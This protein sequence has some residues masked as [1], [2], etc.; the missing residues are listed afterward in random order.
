MQGTTTVIREPR[1]HTYAEPLS[2]LR[3]SWG[4]VLAGTVTLFAVSIFLWLLALAIVMLAIHPAAQS[5][6]ASVLA[7]WICG[8][9]TTLIGAFVGGRVAGSL[10]GSPRRGV[11]AMHGFLSW[12]LALV[13]ASAAQAIVLGGIVRT[14]GNAAAAS[15]AVAASRET[16]E[17]R[18]QAPDI[19]ASTQE[20]E[21]P[22]TQREADSALI[23]YGIGA[24][25]TLFGT[26]AIALVLSVSG[27]A[28]G[29]RR[30]GMRDRLDRAEDDEFEA[31]STRPLEP[32]STP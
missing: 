27:G 1:F 31:R 20:M 9:V 19:L 2:G 3:L 22:G 11:G 14:A 7:L 17:E 6:R 5:L 29:A 24:G 26:W 32:L 8:I 13:L 18:T 21:R 16:I 15:S 28:S 12:A 4:S 10:P 30:S 25:W 23:D